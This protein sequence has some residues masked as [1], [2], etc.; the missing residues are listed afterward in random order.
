M[1]TFVS[2]SQFEKLED[3]KK[4]FPSAARIEEVL[5]GWICFDTWTDYEIWLRQT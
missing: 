2:K 4:A 3:V 1:Q 5:A